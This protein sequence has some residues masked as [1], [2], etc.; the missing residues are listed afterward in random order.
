MAPI[1][2]MS[3]PRYCEF[4]MATQINYTQTYLADHR[5][6]LSHDAVNRYLRGE[7]ITARTVWEHARRQLVLS[8]QGYLLFDDSVLDKNHARHMALV[9]KQWS[10][11]EKRAIRGI[12]LVSCVYVN[13]EV[14]Q[15]WLIDFRIF[16]PDQ[17]GKRKLDHVLEMFQRALEREAADE[18]TFGTVLMD[19][20]YAVNQLMVQIDQAGKYFC[21]PVK[22]N[23]NVRLV[24]GQAR[25]QRADHLDW[26]AEH[27][28]QGYRVHMREAP[29]TF[30]VQLFRLVRSTACTELVVSND[31]TLRTADDLRLTLAVRWAVEVVHRELKQLTGIE[32]CQCR[33]ARAQRNH[34]GLALLCLTRLKSL[35]RQAQI[36][37]YALKAGL[38]GDYM[39][40]QLAHPTLPFA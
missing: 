38:L 35:A 10:G 32:A 33:Q 22:D 40:Q 20:W 7:R 26:S 14:D 18:L 5:E 17:D 28:A 39:R 1:R 27:D 19:R 16:A 9:R 11:N 12:G 34:I 24:G 3:R 37:A 4:L 2:T 8:P 25:F 29:A 13:P 31:P 6:G 36:S 23:R 21:C 30:T 15:A